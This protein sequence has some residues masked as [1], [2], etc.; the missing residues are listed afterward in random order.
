MAYGDKPKKRE[1]DD[2]GN[3]GRKGKGPKPMKGAKKLEENQLSKREKTYLQ[4]TL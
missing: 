2:M 4:K 3:K 1:R